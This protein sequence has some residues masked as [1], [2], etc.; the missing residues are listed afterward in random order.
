[1]KKIIALCVLGLAFGVSANAQQKKTVAQPAKV[2]TATSTTKTATATQK[3]VSNEITQKAGADLN[4][5][6]NLVVLSKAQIEQLKPVFAYKYQ[7]YADVPSLSKDRKDV[8]AQ[9]IESKIKA[10]LTPD[11][12]AKLETNPGLIQKLTH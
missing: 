12:V 7:T 2:A 4:E 1:M 5:L 10:A 9:G 11:Q 8:L 3:P 6:N